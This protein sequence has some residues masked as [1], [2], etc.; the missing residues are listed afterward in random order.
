MGA[1][2][3]QKGIKSHADSFDCDAAG[4]LP[5][6]WGQPGSSFQGTYLLALNVANTGINGSL[7][8]SWGSADSQM[9][10]MIALVVSNASLTGMQVP[11]DLCSYLTCSLHSIC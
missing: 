4:P 3:D 6:E 2:H 7:P 11:R 10:D 1:V 5:A 8:E 9:L